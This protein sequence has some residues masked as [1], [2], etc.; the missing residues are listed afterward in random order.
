M[1]DDLAGEGDVEVTG[2]DGAGVKIIQKLWCFIISPKGNKT[3]NLIN[4]IKGLCGKLRS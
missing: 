2:G 4:P 3:C 1:D